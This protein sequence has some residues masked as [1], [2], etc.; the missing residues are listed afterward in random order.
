MNNIQIQARVQPERYWRGQKY[1]S[2]VANNKLKVSQMFLKYLD[3]W[4]DSQ[5]F[6][7]STSQLGT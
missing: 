7:H 3:R 5:L 6:I 4:H 1:L 2:L